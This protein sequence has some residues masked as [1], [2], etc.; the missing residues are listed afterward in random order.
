MSP[1]GIWGL[2]SLDAV[3][4]ANDSFPN[5]SFPWVDDSFLFA[6]VIF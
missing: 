5:P 1:S 2:V 6:V 4:G 3:L